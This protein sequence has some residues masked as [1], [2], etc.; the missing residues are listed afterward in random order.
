MFRRHP[1]QLVERAICLGNGQRL[2]AP[3][4]VAMLAKI[5]VVR[6]RCFASGSSYGF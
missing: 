6:G 5:V 2:L 3:R 1:T 4:G